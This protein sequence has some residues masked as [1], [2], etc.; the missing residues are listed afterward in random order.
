MPGEG[1]GTHS[2]PLDWKIPWAEEPGGPQSMGSR[3]VGHHRATSLSLFTF[4]HWRRQWRP[5]PVF[6]PGK[7]PGRGRLVGCC[8]WGRTESDTTLRSTAE[9]QQQ[10]MRATVARQCG[11]RQ[12]SFAYDAHNL[13]IS[14]I[15][16]S[17]IYLSAA[18]VGM[19]NH[20]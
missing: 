11:N 8:L 5:T 19:V 4:M 10:R 14:I 3:G 12:L 17:I 7:S 1:K 18:A 13:S 9:R 15:F 2:S 16:L 6:L 20:G